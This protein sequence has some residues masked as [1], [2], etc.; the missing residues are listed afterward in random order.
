MASETDLLTPMIPIKNIYY[1]FLYAWECF[2]EGKQVDVDI[3]SNSDLPNFLASVLI[4]GVQRQ[5]RRG[6]DRRYVEQVEELAAPRGKFLFP[7]TIK[8]SSLRAGRL[9]CEFDELAIDTVPNRILKAAIRHLHQSPDIKRGLSEE[10]RRLER[11]LHGVPDLRLRPSLFRSLQVMRNQSQYGLLMHISRLVMELSL[12][13]RQGSGHQFRDILDDETRMSA[14]F[15]TFLRNFYRTEQALF[16]VA[17][18]RITWPVTSSPLSELRYLPDM[19]TDITLRSPARTI[20]IDAKYYRATFSSGRFGGH[21]KVHSAPLFQIQTYLDHCKCTS[22]IEGLLLFPQV[23]GAPVRLDYQM[24]R[25]RIR[26]CTV[27]LDQPWPAIHGELLDLLGA[28]GAPKKV[29]A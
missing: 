1:L 29:A 24:P 6:L 19:I 12:P 17:S 7:E 3:D 5:F 23:S 20:I 14:V 4:K 15:E 26:V 28:G 11:R 8:Q 25:H 13:D 22:A 27:N 10:L 16:S 9:V 21:P 18:E 2:K